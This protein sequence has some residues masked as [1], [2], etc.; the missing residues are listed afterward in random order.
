[1]ELSGSV[2]GIIDLIGGGSEVTI[3]P[4]VLSGVEILEIKVDDD[5]YHIYCP[6]SDSV[7]VA[8]ELETGTL[9]AT[10][11]VDGTDYLIYAPSA[12]PTDVNVTQ[13]VSTG[14]KIATISVDG[15][16]TDIYV[17]TTTPT[18]V[19]VTQVVSTGTKI[20]TISVDGDD[21]DIYAPES[22][23]GGI[24]FSTTEKEI[25]KWIDGKTLY[26]KVYPCNVSISSGSGV[27]T[28]VVSDMYSIDTY[29]SAI[30]IYNNNARDR[31]SLP[32]TLYQ[33][34]GVLYGSAAVNVTVKNL[35]LIY[36]KTS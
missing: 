23:G 32:I 34:G 4:K 17:P 10:I 31:G 18:D 30:G 11:T 33:N 19:D 7:S 15:D 5:T 20:A 35:V 1:M 24:E 6:D 12:T 21:T 36:T 25:G 27:F 3:T 22:S 2:Q 13:V 16:D 14:T 26:S 29:V 8:P 9:I 28:N